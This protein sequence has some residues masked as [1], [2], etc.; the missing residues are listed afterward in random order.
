MKPTLHTVGL[1]ALRLG[2]QQQHIV[3][4]CSRGRI[5]FTLAGRIRI[6]RDEDVEDVRQALIEAGYLKEAAT[7]NEACAV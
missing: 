3:R 4:L 6:I 5:P 2:V 1:L 7:K